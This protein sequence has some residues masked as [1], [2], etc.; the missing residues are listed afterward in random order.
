MIKDKLRDTFQLVRFLSR[1]ASPAIS[2]QLPLFEEKD[3]LPALFLTTLN[4]KKS[5]EI[6]NVRPAGNTTTILTDTYRLRT[7]ARTDNGGQ[8]HR[9]WMLLKEKRREKKLFFR[10]SPLI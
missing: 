9:C 4:S 10:Y 2:V 6:A 1:R 5:R 3:L 7:I 8:Y